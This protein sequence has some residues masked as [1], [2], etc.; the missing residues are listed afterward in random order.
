M[1]GAHRPPVRL[2]CDDRGSGGEDVAALRGQ[3][4]AVIGRFIADFACF[5]QKVVVELDGGQH[6]EQVVYDGE[7]SHW[8]MTGISA[9]CASGT[10]TCCRTSMVSSQGLLKRCVRHRPRTSPRPNL[11]PRFAG[12]GGGGG[13][14]TRSGCR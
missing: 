8:L 4:Q 14:R 3:R 1:A 2:S 10:T 13:K 11:P 6:A 12:G 7:K 9:S 5:E